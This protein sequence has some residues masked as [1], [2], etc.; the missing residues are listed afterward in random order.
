VVIDACVL[1]RFHPCDTIL[2]LAESPRLFEPKWTDAILA[3]TTRTL[4]ERIQWPAHL[5]QSFESELRANFQEAWIRDYEHL[6]ANM[7][8][9]PKDRH[10]AAAAVWIKA[11]AILTFNLK[12]FAPE[13]LERFGVRALDPDRFLLELVGIEP[14]LV[15]TKLEQQAFDRNRSLADLIAILDKIVPQFAARLREVSQSRKP[16]Q[17]LSSL[18]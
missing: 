18:R 7:T 2:R 1:A 4:R 10:V 16:R 9:D 13:H 14:S 17:G 5:V 12:D 6:T 15:L 3:E 8:N 11:D